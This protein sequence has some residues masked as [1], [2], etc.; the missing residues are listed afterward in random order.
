LYFLNELFFIILN[1]QL[2]KV[3]NVFLSEMAS[4]RSENGNNLAHE[5]KNK[6]IPEKTKQRGKETLLLWA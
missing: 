2:L 1:Y 6:T 3:K 5:N 4:A